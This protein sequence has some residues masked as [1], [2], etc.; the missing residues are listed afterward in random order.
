[1]ERA[2]AMLPFFIALK[3][4]KDMNIWMNFLETCPI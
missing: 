1:M 4:D 2:A 3:F